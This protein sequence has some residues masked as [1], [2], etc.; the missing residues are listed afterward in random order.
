[1][2]RYYNIFAALSLCAG[3]T[4]TAAAADYANSA[5]VEGYTIIDAG[6]YST[7]RFE[8]TSARKVMPL[9]SDSSTNAVQVSNSSGQSFE[10]Y[11][12]S[13]T[14]AFT[15]SSHFQAAEISGYAAAQ[16]GSVHARARNS[17]V[18]APPSILTPDHVPYLP[19]PYTAIAYIDVEALS[20][21][22]LTI[23]S[24][25][26]TNGTPITFNWNLYMEGS[27][28]NTG[29]QP[30]NVG[31]S[32]LFALNL[33]AGFGFGGLQQV[34]GNGSDFG[35]FQGLDW[36]VPGQLPVAVKVGDTIPIYSDI[37]LFG[38]AYVDAANSANS[39]PWEWW[40]SGC[41]VLLP[42]DP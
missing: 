23:A 25:T 19:S 15:A 7:V 42:Y 6:P 28:L 8:T 29:Y 36:F 14:N 41:P 16:A 9:V 24:A 27:A 3:S 26:L 20:E 22:S 13:V 37:S 32:Y 17:A 40:S 35:G 11:D 1:M 21:D 5:S 12:A 31:S 39:P 10:T 30:G 18:A 38:N 33:R 34:I 4:R 2:N